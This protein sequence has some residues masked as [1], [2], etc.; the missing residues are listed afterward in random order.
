MRVWVCPNY[1]CIRTFVTY[2]FVKHGFVSAGVLQCISVLQRAAVCCSVLQCAVVS[3]SV[4]QRDA[5]C[6]VVVQCVQ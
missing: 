2:I 6:I 5:V 3:C 4:L 1:V